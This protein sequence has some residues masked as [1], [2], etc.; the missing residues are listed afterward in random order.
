L[1]SFCKEGGRFFWS[2][3]IYSLADYAK[4]NKDQ[5]FLLMDW[6][7]NNQL[8]L[9]SGGAVKKLDMSWTLAETRPEAEEEQID[10]LY[11]WTWNPSSVFLFHTPQHSVRQEPKNL[12]QKML[13]KYGLRSDTS[14]LFFQRDG[15]VVYSLERVFKL[16]ESGETGSSRYIFFREAE[17]FDDKSGG[18]SMPN[19]QP[20]RVTPW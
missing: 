6:G 19:R 12:F 20:L 4:Q 8:L 18:P 7:F 13:A 16:P 1:R 9:L 5:T 17:A 10:A 15:Q 2:D 14:E 3:A 11:R